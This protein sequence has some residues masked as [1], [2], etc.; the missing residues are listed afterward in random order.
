M[1]STRIRGFLASSGAVLALAA[2]AVT[3]PPAVAVGQASLA[4]VTAYDLPSCTSNQWVDGLAVE[5]WPDGHFK[6]VIS[7]SVDGFTY[8][9]AGMDSIW[10][11]VQACVPGL[12][13]SLADSIWS[14]LNCHTWF[15]ALPEW[16]R[17][18][19]GSGFAS[20]PSWDLESWHPNFHFTKYVTSHCGNELGG[21]IHPEAGTWAVSFGVDPFVKSEQ[22]LQVFAQQRAYAPAYALNVYVFQ[23]GGV[24]LW[25]RQGP[26]AGGGLIEVLA[27]GRSMTL[28]CQTRGVLVTEWMTTDLWDK[29]RLDDGREVFVS[30]AF[31]HT[32]SDGQVAPSC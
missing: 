24:G 10:H 7:P 2:G 32:G 11:L 29:V 25:A 31:V 9:H 5:R 1:S 21:D 26:N 27:E 15:S 28:L 30:D 13:G 17:Y 16:R 3:A 19:S 22:E 6:V 4:Q 12:Y 8:G 20:G 18:E 23:T 14:Q